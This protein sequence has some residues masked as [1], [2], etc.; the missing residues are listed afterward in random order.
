M[1][2]YKNKDDNEVKNIPVPWA[3]INHL[4]L[5]IERQNKIIEELE[6]KLALLRATN[7]TKNP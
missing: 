4:L 1:V 2:E 7:R 6:K 5:I 3:E